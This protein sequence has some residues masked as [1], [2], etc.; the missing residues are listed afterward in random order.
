MSADGDVYEAIAA[1]V[2]EAREPDLSSF[3]P[4]IVDAAV[5]RALAPL[6]RADFLVWL[7]RRVES[8]SDGRVTITGR[9]EVQDPEV[10]DGPEAEEVPLSL[11]VQG[12]PFR[13]PIVLGGAVPV[14][15][16]PMRG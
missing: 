12:E 11:V 14:V 9:S 4:E 6:R 3:T 16:Y 5:R 1:G 2:A 7:G 13:E 10:D 8:L 15:R